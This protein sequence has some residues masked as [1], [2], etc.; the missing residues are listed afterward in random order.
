MIEVRLN[1]LVYEGSS[2]SGSAR[3]FFKDIITAAVPCPPQGSGYHDDMIELWPD[4]PTETVRQRHWGSDG[5]MQVDLRSAVVDPLLMEERMISVID[6]TWHRRHWTWRT[7]QEESDLV[8]QLTTL[9]GWKRR[10][11]VPGSGWREYEYDSADDLSPTDPEGA[12]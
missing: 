1:L 2:T 9:G 5:V 7:D 3:F 11:Y 4:G 8:Q 6:G 10:I 12:V